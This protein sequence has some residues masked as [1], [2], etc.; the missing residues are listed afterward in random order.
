MNFG[1]TVGKTAILVIDMLKDFV[2]GVLGSE[3]AGKIV[4]N[5]KTLLDKAREKKI[6]VIYVNDA[7][8]PQIDE[9]FKLWGPHAVKGTEGAEVID[10]IKPKA[11]DFVL[12]KRRYSGFFETGLDLLL[13]ELGVTDLILVGVTTDICVKHTAADAFYRGYKIIVPRDCV[14]SFK[15]SDHEWALNYMQKIYGVEVTDVKEVLGRI[16]R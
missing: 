1:E 10:E 6:P 13:R 5:I 2:S 8:L 7:H 11:G 3:K 4:P 12:E 14:A 9:E 15:E 16:T